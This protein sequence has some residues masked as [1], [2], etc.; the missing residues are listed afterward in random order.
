MAEVSSTGLAAPKENPP[1]K[2]FSEVHAQPVKDEV[3]SQSTEDSTAVVATGESRPESSQ[4]PATR[5]SAPAA[6]TGEDASSAKRNDPS[7]SAQDAA[8][9]SMPNPVPSTKDESSQAAASEAEPPRPV[10]DEHSDGKASE[11][12]SGLEA[13]SGTGR[14]EQGAEEAEAESQSES[15][16]AGAVDAPPLAG[17]RGE[18]D[19][20][21]PSVSEERTTEQ[22]Q[23]SGAQA[24]PDADSSSNSSSAAG[25]TAAARTS[26]GSQ[27][28][29]GSGFAA[30]FGSLTF[31]RAPIGH[32]A[33]EDTSATASRGEE[34]ASRSKE[35]L[36]NGSS[37]SHAKPAAGQESDAA[38][39]SI[40]SPLE[41][42]TTPALPSSTGGFTLLKSLQTQARHLVSQNKRRYQV[43]TCDCH[44]NFPL[45]AKLTS[46]P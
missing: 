18:G 44:C 42:S 3:A 39:A 28:A 9:D 19:P 20:P 10:I 5:D 6:A 22:P 1:G 37:A 34:P 13:S 31:G 8:S 4:T 15:S 38:A 12:S 16:K 30:L 43:C 14:E 24:S 17:S 11:T 2:R 35:P 27:P 32:A 25:A 36:V 21:A 23:Q 7:P 46:S 45:R 40:A 29:I 33:K 26:S 41:A